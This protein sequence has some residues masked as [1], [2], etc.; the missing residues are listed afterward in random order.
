[1]KLHSLLLAC[2][3]GMGL[4][5]CSSEHYTH[6]ASQLPKKATEFIS[7]NFTSSV[8]VVEIEKNLGTTKEYEVTLTDGT[9]ISFNKSGEWESVE[10]APNKSVPSGVIPTSIAGFVAQKQQGASIVGIERDNKGYEVELSNG[11]EIKFDNSGNFI[12]YDK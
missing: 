4:I 9:E 8:S 1:M 10:S 3:F 11:V 12:K 2:V 5:A 6:D 7:K